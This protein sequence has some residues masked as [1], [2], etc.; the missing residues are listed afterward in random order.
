M[1]ITNNKMSLF[2]QN[3]IFMLKL[4]CFLLG[5]LLRKSVCL[6][7]LRTKVA[8]QII[9]VLICDQLVTCNSSSLEA[10]KK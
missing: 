5:V 4:M 10:E 8:T 3:L 7:S 6:F 1:C 9:H 2:Q